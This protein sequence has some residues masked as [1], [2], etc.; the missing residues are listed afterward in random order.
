M[1]NLVSDLLIVGKSPVV[2]VVGTRPEVIKMAPVIEAL[3]ATDWALPIVVSSGQHGNLLDV[4]LNDFD[5][6]ADYY[7]EVNRSRSTILEVVTQVITQLEDL[8]LKLKPLSLV[9]QGDTSTVAASSMVAF[10]HNVHFIHVEA[11][12]RS[13]NIR[14]PFPEE[15]NRRLVALG[16]NLHCAPTR[17]AVDNLIAEGIEPEKII[18]SG[19]TVVDALLSMTKRE[20]ELPEN[21]PDVK[22]LILLTAHRRE[23]QG[24]PLERIFRTIR[25]FVE[26]HEDVGV[27]FPVHPNPASRAAAVKEL[28]DHPRI[29]LIEPLS[30]PLMIALMQ[31]VWL[32]MSD[33]GGVQ[34]E[35]TSLGKPTLLLRDTTERP[36]A[37]ASG[38]VRLVGTEP[39]NVLIAMEEIYG[40]DEVYANMAKPSTVFGDGKAAER[41]IKAMTKLCAKGT[42]CQDGAS[43]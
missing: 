34:E 38:V 41:I 13:D 5:L 36:D 18:L 16:T 40:S 7:L 12:L 39:K 26:A 24:A 10:H 1:E 31:S 17:E 21:L 30:Y 3:R 42:I 19:N 20:Q 27:V 4:A 37:V 22:R 32:V 35:A 15:Y 25:Q 14:N 43:Y 2:C 11:G 23:N 9:A 28:S 8:V 6:Q 29:L 33:S